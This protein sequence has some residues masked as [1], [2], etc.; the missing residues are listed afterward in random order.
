M[1][2]IGLSGKAGS[3]KNTI[4]QH[5]C[6]SQEM[7][8]FSFASSIKNMISAL[9]YEQADI[10]LWVEE[11]KEDLIPEM[12]ITY[13]EAMQGLGDW[14]RNHHPNFWIDA[15][16]KSHNYQFAEREIPEAWAVITDVRFDNEADWIRSQ[17]GVI[18]HIERPGAIKVK[19]HISEAG[20]T[21]RPGEVIIMNDGCFKTLAQQVDLHLLRLGF[22]ID[23]KTP[24]VTR[25]SGKS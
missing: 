22:D 25:R 17:G 6:L 13:R 12:N 11:G 24:S 5:I 20:I 15:L 23:Y 4:A 8:E 18:W 21:K 3:G 14:G 9:M 10:G 19:D 16:K 7:W 2:F 1:K